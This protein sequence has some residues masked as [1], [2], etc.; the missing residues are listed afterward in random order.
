M[1]LGNI[2]MLGFTIGAIVY[3]K[4]F[5]VEYTPIVP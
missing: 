2:F 1:E 5:T 4:G 3:L